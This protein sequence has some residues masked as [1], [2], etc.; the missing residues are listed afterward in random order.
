MRVNAPSR[1][2]PHHGTSLPTALKP[3]IPMPTSGNRPTLPPPRF[4]LTQSS[5]TFV[6]SPP[7]PAGCRSLVTKLV[8]GDVDFKIAPMVRHDFRGNAIDLLTVHSSPRPLTDQA[9]FNL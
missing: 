6:M 1:S 3:R 4:L 5:A 8:R 7:S 2:A 9:Y